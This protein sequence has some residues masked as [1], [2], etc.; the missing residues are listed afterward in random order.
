MNAHARIVVIAS[1]DSWYARDLQ[2][3]AEARGH[4]MRCVSFSQ[5]GARINESKEW[6]SKGEGEG[7]GTT[8]R[9]GSDAVIVRTM[10]PGSLEQIVF[11]MNALA[12]LE[13]MGVPVLNP[14][15]ALE[16]AVD[17]Y[18]ALARLKDAGFLVPDTFACQTLPAAREAFERLGGDVVIKPLF[19]GEGRGILRVTDSVLMTRVASALVQLQSI[20]YV[21]RFIPHHGADQRLLVVGEEVFG[22]VRENAGDW[23]TNVSLGATT[24]PLPMTPRLVEQAHAAASI[25]GAPLCALDLLPGRDGQTYALEVN[26]VPGWRALNRT[27]DVDIADRV[28]SLTLRQIHAAQRHDG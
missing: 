20:V 25:V 6:V 24:R 23:R 14:P 16:I 3:A 4:A 11:R 7:E 26:A 13:C 12:R 8:G 28:V 5:L 9:E 21:Q 27:L 18:L 19:G 1:A 2:R 15:R 10:P 22:M 17:K